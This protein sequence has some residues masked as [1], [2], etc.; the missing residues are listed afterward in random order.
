MNLLPETQIKRDH[1]QVDC[2]DD[3]YSMIEKIR[4]LHE[5]IDEMEVSLNRKAVSHESPS[6]DTDQTESV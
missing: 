4:S 6:R 5:I 2:G 3:Y 1:L